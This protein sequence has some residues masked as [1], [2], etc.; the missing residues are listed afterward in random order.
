MSVAGLSKVFAA[1][2]ITVSFYGH[3]QTTVPPVEMVKM[4][5]KIQAF[6]N[7]YIDLIKTGRLH[8]DFNPVF[9][10]KKNGMTTLNFKNYRRGL[11][12]FNFS[13]EFIGKKINEYNT[14]VTN[15]EKTPYETF[16]QYQDLDDYEAIDCAFSNGYEWFGGDMEP[17]GSVDV[18]RLVNMTDG[19]VVAMVQFYDTSYGLYAIPAGQARATFR[20]KN[21]GWMI[22]DLEFQKKNQQ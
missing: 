11:S 13:E 20:K 5:G 19:R 10:R 14:C 8:Q 16:T 21:K 6:Y 3:G 4:S 22:V 12:K 7:W 2:A 1:F 18:L 15:L 17:A 9:V